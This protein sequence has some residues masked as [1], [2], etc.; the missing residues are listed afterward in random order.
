MVREHLHG[1]TP[2]VTLLMVDDKVRAVA[3]DRGV[4]A[5]WAETNSIVSFDMVDHEVIS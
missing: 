1:R 4:L 3:V 2:I 5:K